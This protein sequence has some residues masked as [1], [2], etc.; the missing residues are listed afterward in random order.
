MEK[1]SSTT[2]RIVD[3]PEGMPPVRTRWDKATIRP[4]RMVETVAV[5]TTDGEVTREVHSIVLGG[6]ILTV[7]GKPSSSRRGEAAYGR[8]TGDHPLGSIPPEIAAHAVVLAD[9]LGD[10]EG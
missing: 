8:E 10:L 1:I 4:V 3:L 6:P 9:V 5:E 2:S 7:S